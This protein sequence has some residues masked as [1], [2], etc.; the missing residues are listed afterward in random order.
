MEAI[1][2]QASKNR[3]AILAIKRRYLLGEITRDEAKELAEPVIRQI[4][5]QGE[6]V[7]K[8]WNKKYTPQTFI[9]LMR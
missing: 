8:R 4:N 6:V 7:A 3:E 5:K 9:G 1:A 2:E